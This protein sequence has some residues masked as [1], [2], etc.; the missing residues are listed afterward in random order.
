[1][2]TGSLHNPLASRFSRAFCFLYRWSL[3]GRLHLGLPF[4]FFAGM[5]CFLSAAADSAVIVSGV[6]A[7]AGTATADV[8]AV[9]AAVVAAS[10]IYKTAE[11]DALIPMELLASAR[12]LLIS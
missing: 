12:S 10:A 5:V 7:A 8:A 2:A 6:A 3:V 9:A 1:V 11:S 4:L